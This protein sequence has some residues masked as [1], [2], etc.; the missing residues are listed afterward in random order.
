MDVT[1]IRAQNIKKILSSLRHT[2]G[3]TKNEIAIMTEL[4][5]STVSNLCNELKAKGVLLE[6]K[7]TG[8]SVGRTPS[9]QI[10]AHD[11]F[12]SVCLDF[13]QGKT[14]NVAVLS[15]ANELLY[16]SQVPLEGIED[17]ETLL[18][19]TRGAAAEAMGR[20]PELSVV[21]IGVSIPGIYDAAERYISSVSV[22]LL[23]KLPLKDFLEEEFHIPCYI[24]NESNLCVIAAGQKHE[25]V[26][27]ILYL[28]SSFGLGVGV[29]CEGQLLRGASGF[30]A[31]IA[32]IP[33]GAGDL[34]CPVCGSNSCA[35]RYLSMR[36][37]EPPE[38]VN[39]G[40]FYAER[41]EKLGVLL[42]VL[43]NLFDPGIV[44]L[45]GPGFSGYDR[46]MP[47]ARPVM[48]RRCSEYARAALR[49]Y[50]DP[51]SLRTIETGTNQ[52]I[53]EAWSPL[54]D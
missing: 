21:G 47:Y 14:L 10:F 29:I 35:E 30:A 20:F 31:E 49:I 1:D 18:D 54:G 32:H 41:G 3:F 28:Y 37:L 25:G 50:H 27:N 48:N 7:L 17:R 13:Q 24:E 15:F 2:D 39:E 16:Q 23:H 6:E 43:V 44:Y 45:G 33:V 40:A 22:P 8:S 36:G 12:G 42:S 46:L 4:S 19:R 11:R 53:Y 5:F 26:R 9:R 34:V 52:M 51:E 38:G